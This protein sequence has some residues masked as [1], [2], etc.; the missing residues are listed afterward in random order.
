[1][2]SN[3]SLHAQSGYRP[4][5][6]P[7]PSI[8][9]VRVQIIGYIGPWLVYRVQGILNRRNLSFLLPN[10][11]PV[12]AYASSE[13]SSV[14]GRLGH[15]H[16][17]ITA[18]TKA[19]CL[20]FLFPSL[21]WAVSFSDCLGR[22]SPSYEHAFKSAFSFFSL[23]SLETGPSAPLPCRCSLPQRMPFRPFIMSFFLGALLRNLLRF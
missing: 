10:A 23:F 7:R 4:A 9:S 12:P 15:R 5:Y 22:V 13:P 3:C 14:M 20:K 21:P 18:H 16:S 11:L 19:T 2:W 8:K 17:P 1:M 6:I